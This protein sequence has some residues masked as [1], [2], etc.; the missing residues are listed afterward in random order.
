LFGPRK[1]IVTEEHAIFG[2]PNL[3]ANHIYFLQTY[4]HDEKNEYWIYQQ[5]IGIV[6]SVNTTHA[7]RIKQVRGDWIWLPGTWLLPSYP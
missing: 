1:C 7:I 6:P 4:H 5:G 3:W 2:L